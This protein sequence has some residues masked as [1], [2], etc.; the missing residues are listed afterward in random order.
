MKKNVM[1]RLSALLLVAVLLTT[2]VISGTFA[3][4]VTTGSGSE[5][6]QVAKWG[7]KIVAPS[8]TL[9]AKNYD[10]TVSTD[11]SYELVAPG[12]AGTLAD[13]TITGSPEVDVN[14]TYS[15]VLTLSNW[16]IGDPATEY[17]P[18]IFTVEDEKYYV[19]K[20]GI[21]SVAAL[22]TA[23]QNAIAAVSQKYEIGETITDTL[24][25]SWAWEF[26]QSTVPG[27]TDAND[28][29]LGDL[30]AKPTVTLNVT[31]T[32]TQVD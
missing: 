8:D 5:T 29:A 30:A 32:V 15:A 10:N 14:V 1:M 9:F 16:N 2:C 11:A 21:D 26:E 4:Y 27:Q 25:V 17:C 22:I 7:V 12:T 23:V 18:L 20:T 24:D 28:T 6:A 31:C 19:G 3:K 13:F